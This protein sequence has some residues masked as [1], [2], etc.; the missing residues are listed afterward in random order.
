MCNLTKMD[1]GE[2]LF[3]NSGIECTYIIHTNIIILFRIPFN[4]DGLFPHQQ[5]T[6]YPSYSTYTYCKSFNKNIIILII[7][8]FI[9]LSSMDNLW[10]SHLDGRSSSVVL[11]ISTVFH[12]LSLINKCTNK[13]HCQFFFFLNICFYCTFITFV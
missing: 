4:E 13:K 2:W 11:N 8:P 3:T 6:Q 5:S 10:L 7:S 12:L 1:G 9:D